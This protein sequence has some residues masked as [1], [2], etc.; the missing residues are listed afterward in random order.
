[1]KRLADTAVAR[2]AAT[3]AVIGAMASAVL[4]AG[5]LPAAATAR[6]TTTATHEPQTH[7]APLPGNPVFGRYLEPPRYAVPAWPAKAVRDG[8]VAG[9]MYAFGGSPMN[10]ATVAWYTRRSG[11]W[12]FG[13]STTTAAAG[14]Y[15]FAAVPASAAGALRVT[16]PRGGPAAM[17]LQAGLDFPGTG[18]ATFDLRPGRVDWTTTRD[19]PWPDWDSP[20]VSLENTG[21]SGSRTSY[22]E[23]IEVALVSRTAEAAT[24]AV[25]YG[26]LTYWWDEADEWF[27]PAGGEIAVRTGSVGGGIAF[28]EIDALRTVPVSPCALPF[29]L[30]SSPG[31]AVTIAMDNWPAGHVAAFFGIP[32]YPAGE[33]WSTFDDRTFV[34]AST[35]PQE[36]SFTI[37]PTARAGYGYTIAAYRPDVATSDVFL[38]E[39]VQLARLRSRLADGG[40]RLGGVVPTKGHRG[41]QAGIRKRVVIFGKTQESGAPSTWDPRGE[42]WKKVAVLRCNGFGVFRSAVLHPTRTSWY[43][44]RYA[45]DAWYWGAYTNVV[46]VTGY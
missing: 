46:E 5:T 15:S 1:M 7:G 30:G 38:Q 21:D 10:G 39:Y 3:T 8:G 12:L 6:S 17:F 28:H 14:A 18:S 9:H 16:Y 20:S 33:A 23:V 29:C 36:L 44:A 42:G 35:D 32:D 13:Q 24:G 37:P 43:V 34:S 27:A 11:D 22:S 26:C 19:G 4:F 2:V 31:G 40:V 25:D 45:K 41:P